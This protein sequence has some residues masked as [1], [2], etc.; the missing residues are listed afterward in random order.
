MPEPE[1]EKPSF[2][3]TTFEIEDGISDA[4]LRAIGEKRIAIEGF[5][6]RDVSGRK[7]PFTRTHDGFD[8][9]FMGGIDHLFG[10]DEI[11]QI[12]IEADRIKRLHWIAPILSGRCRF[13]LMND[14]EET[15]EREYYLPRLK[16]L[17]VLGRKDEKSFKLVTAYGVT[18]SKKLWHLE[19]LFSRFL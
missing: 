8:V 3:L 4:D 11:K 10:K 17:I 18:D 14:I 19:M 1:K 12:E 15:N 9:Y 16:Y 7:L 13:V 2:K 6:N 5:L